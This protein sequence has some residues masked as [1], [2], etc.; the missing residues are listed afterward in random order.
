LAVQARGGNA[1]LQVLLP[2]G[3]R[4]PFLVGSAVVV[5]RVATL[6]L[7]P[8]G[9]LNGRKAT[10]PVVVQGGIA[11]RRVEPL[12][13]LGP[14]GGQ[15]SIAAVLADHGAVLAF[16]QGVVGGAVGPRLGE[17]HQQLVQQPGR[18]S[19][20]RPPPATRCPG[21]C[22]DRESGAGE[23]VEPGGTLSAATVGSSG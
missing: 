6:P 19:S 9:E 20:R 22:S 10:R 15:G 3:Q 4:E 7:P 18:T 2:V 12:P 5:D 17:L 21:A 23:P 1:R 14:L 13:G 11:V 16:Y 8:L